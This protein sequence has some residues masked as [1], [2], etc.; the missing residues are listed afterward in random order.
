MKKTQDSPEHS[1]DLSPEIQIIISI[2]EHA[3]SIVLSH[4]KRQLDISTKNNDA[5]NFLTQADKQS[6]QY[7]R[8]E[9]KRVFPRDK[10]LLEETAERPSSY[11]GRVWMVDPLDGT[12]E[13]INGGDHFA[14]MIGLCVDGQ[15]ILGC[16]VRP[17]TGDVFWAEKGKGAYKLPNGGTDQRLR[18]DDVADFS[19]ARAIVSIAHGELRSADKL[20]NSLPIKEAIPGA[21]LGLR[22]TDIAERKAEFFVNTNMRA[23]KWDSCAPQIILEEAGGTVTDMYG[24]PL[25]YLQSDHHWKNS[26]VGSNTALHTTVVD[27]IKGIESLLS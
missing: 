18:V 26:F 10:L 19:Q 20:L 3:A 23:C 21:S 2:A 7:I 24:K 25:D 14:V 8:D 12:K 16:V 5:F 15:P 6:N 13:F 27:R 4:F 11:E 22:A 17:T 1:T 9:L